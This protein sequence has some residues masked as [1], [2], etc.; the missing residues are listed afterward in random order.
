MARTTTIWK[1]TKWRERQEEIEREETE[2][3]KKNEHKTNDTKFVT[4]LHS[5]QLRDDGDDRIID[6]LHSH[7]HLLLLL[8]TLRSIRSAVR[9]RWT[10]VHVCMTSNDSDNDDE[11]K[12]PKNEYTTATDTDTKTKQTFDV[13]KWSERD[14]LLSIIIIMNVVVRIVEN[15]ENCNQRKSRFDRK[16]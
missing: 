5:Y 14:K 12:V 11:K 16:R 9:R 3:E 7:Y 8:N 1:Q 6:I 13:M 2:R 10:C 4:L 15:V